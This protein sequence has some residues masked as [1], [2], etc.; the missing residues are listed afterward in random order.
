LQFHT[1]ERGAFLLRLDHTGGP[2]IDEEHVVGFTVAMPKREFSNSNPTTSF[3]IGAGSVLDQLAGGLQQIVDSLSGLIFWRHLQGYW[4]I[5]VEAGT[6]R[7]HEMRSRQCR[8]G[9]MIKLPSEWLQIRSPL[10]SNICNDVAIQ[11]MH[12]T[13]P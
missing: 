12:S 3:Q 5:L 13:E 8:N 6:C 2:A 1:S 9:R 4:Q 7:Y 11:R 10:T